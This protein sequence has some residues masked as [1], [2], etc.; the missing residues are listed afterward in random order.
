[1]VTTSQWNDKKLETSEWQVKSVEKWS[2]V[3]GTIRTVKTSEWQVK[4]VEKW[5]LVSG[6]MKSSRLANGR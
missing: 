2:L 3:S 1:M 5:S 4:S 6:T